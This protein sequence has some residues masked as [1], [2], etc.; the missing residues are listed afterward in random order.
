MPTREL[1]TQKNLWDYYLN[2]IRPVQEE[3]RR[4]VLR[5]KIIDFDII[6]TPA[7][8][9]TVF[10]NCEFKGC[11]T[12]QAGYMSEY[13]FNTYYNSKQPL[14]RQINTDD[15]F[16]EVRTS[17]FIRAYVFRNNCEFKKCIYA[18]DI[19]FEENFRIYDSQIEKLHFRNATF[20]GLADFWRTKFKQKTIFYKTDFNATVVFS[21]A[22]FYNNVLFTYSLLAGKSIFAK[23]EFKQGLDLS[24]AIISGNLQLFDIHFDNE[25]FNTEYFERSQ[26]YDYQ[27]AIDNDGII[28]VENKVH[29]FQILR[30]AYED[31][32][33]YA[34]ATKMRKMEKM[35][36]RNY[37]QNK[38]G[39]PKPLKI[40]IP[41]DENYIKSWLKEPFRAFKVLN[42][43]ELKS[44]DGL[45]LYFNRRSNKYRT[46]FWTGIWFTCRVVIVFSFLTLITTCSF[47]HHLPYKGHTTF[48][49][50]AIENGVR[51]L[52][53][54]FN[55]ARKMN[56][57][58]ALGPFLG[59]AYVF[60][61]L[62][63]I[64]VGYGIYQT[65]QAFRKFK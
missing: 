27:N 16:I 57:L 6:L 19:T 23:T 26:K 34:D 18:N 44:N 38:I 48:D 31:V 58:A 17:H 2:P 24:Q 3:D 65:V 63:R 7:T 61:F 10:E 60:D 25:A 22:E 59:I 47:W 15:P 21:M 5:D 28:P 39:L 37:N 11:V 33:N 8:S 29:T 64:A 1:I 52:I 14:Q 35:A 55:P 40:N 20:N 50:D 49:I 13:V 54:F 62:G 42:F 9:M 43:S 32:G 12:F 36:F 41:K 51:F 56:Y 53:N 4:D 46:S 30:K 45:I